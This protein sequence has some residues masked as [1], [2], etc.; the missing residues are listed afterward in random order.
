MLLVLTE[1]FQVEAEMLKYGQSFTAKEFC[2]WHTQVGHSLD[3][4]GCKPFTA[5]SKQNYSSIWWIW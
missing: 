3:H 4:H 2:G 5:S 1:Q